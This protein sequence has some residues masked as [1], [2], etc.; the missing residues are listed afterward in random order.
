MD[1]GKPDSGKGSRASPIVHNDSTPVAE[2][3][4][5]IP[6]DCRDGIVHA[7]FLM[8]G[9]GHVGKGNRHQ[10]HLGKRGEG[11]MFI[12]SSGD[13][14][15]PLA[16]LAMGQRK[17]PSLGSG[18]RLYCCDYC[19]VADSLSARADAGTKAKGGLACLC[20]LVGISGEEFLRSYGGC[21]RQI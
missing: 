3:V 5:A 20:C 6:L 2:A 17:R 10:I 21:N 13:T 8:L 15:L 16:L 12:A 14:P 1:N 9:S 11:S 7:Y 19:C 18:C 4:H